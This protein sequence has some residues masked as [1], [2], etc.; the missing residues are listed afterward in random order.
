VGHIDAIPLIVATGF[1]LA[2]CGAAAEPRPAETRSI[3]VSWAEGASSTGE[4][5]E[6][7]EA[8]VV[9][10][11]ESTETAEVTDFGA[12]TDAT[13]RVDTWAKSTGEEPETIVIRQTGGVADGVFFQVDDDPL[14]QVGER[15]VFFVRYVA[16]RG[17]Y[18]VLGGPTGRFTVSGDN[19]V[20]L[21]GSAMN[22]SGALKVDQLVKGAGG[23]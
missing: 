23:S 19:A 20:P 18:V 15:G 4:L 21:P 1:F 9:G 10:S 8:V 22:G 11:V 3:E 13:I 16:D 7:A 6:K 12:L 14:L 5:S 2:G 17:V